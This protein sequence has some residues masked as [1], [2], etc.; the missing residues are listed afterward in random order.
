MNEPDQTASFRFAQSNGS[1]RQKS[2][3]LDDAWTDDEFSTDEDQPT[4]ER[5]A[6]FVSLAFIIASLKRS[7]WLCIVSALIAL[8]LGAALYVKFP[9]SYAATV[10]VLLTNNT[11]SDTSKQAQTNV[12]LSQS[13]AVASAALKKLGLTQS[14]S[15]FIAAYT[16]TAVS[17]QVIAFQVSGPNT[18]SA[19][20]RAAAIAQSFLQFR[21]NYLQGQQQLQVTLGQQQVTLAEQKLASINRRIADLNAA[22]AAGTAG[23][24]YG[25]KLSSLKAQQST[26]ETGVVSAQQN[27]GSVQTTAAAATASQIRGSE[28]LNSPTP[29][30]HSFKESK[31]FYLVLALIAGT[32]IGV[33]IIVVRALVSDRLRNRDDIADAIGGPVMLSTGE[34]GTNWLPP[35]LQRRRVSSLDVRRLAAHLNGAIVTP[36]GKRAAT[37][38]VV[39][40]DNEQDVVPAVVSLAADWAGQG[41]KVVLVDLCHGAPAAR[42][43]GVRRPGVHSATVSGA[44]LTVSVPERDDP[45][46]VGPLPTPSHLQFGHVHPD[47]AAAHMT[48]D[49]MLTLVN[50]QP[51]SGSDHLGSWATQAVALVTAGRSSSTRIRAVGE[52]IR[53]AG[54]R[55]ASVVLL[56]ADESDESLGVLGTLE[57]SSPL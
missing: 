20:A 37:L 53:L 2:D 22:I 29:V 30:P 44:D 18:L 40:I 15:S 43:L 14:V 32:A 8:V 49:Y 55:L 1:F 24:D 10:S 42:K 27:L 13:Q 19:E 48:A 5:G 34:V 28:I 33:A 11:L 57:R 54:P 4:V 36:M 52:M 47:V 6:A 7:A 38:A 50:L 35:R 3:G 45:A 39:A 51:L 46:P 56:Q 9:P 26:S 16:V 25:A 23:S 17:D 21:A 12:A 31:V 41:K